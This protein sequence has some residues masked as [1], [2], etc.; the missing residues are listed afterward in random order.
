MAK[1]M[2]TN[3]KLKN[4]FKSNFS[5]AGYAIEI[6]RNYVLSGYFNNLDNLILEIRRRAE[7]INDPEKKQKLGLK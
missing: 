4:L 1:K 5:L 3:E 7:S 6:G 2:L